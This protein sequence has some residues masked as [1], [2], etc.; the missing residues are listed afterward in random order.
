MKVEDAIIILAGNGSRMLP[1]SMYCP[2]EFL[3]LVNIPLIHHLVWEAVS[4]G[5]K[6]LHFVTSDEKLPFLNKMIEGEKNLLL[7]RPDLHPLH[8]KPILPEIEVK[9]HIQVKPKGVGDAISLGCKSIEGPFLVLLGDNALF[10]NKINFDQLGPHHPSDAC[11]ILIR[12][13]YSNNTPSIGVLK[14]PKSELYKYGVVELENNS[15]KNI[16]EKPPKSTAPSNLII[17]GRY[18]FPDGSYEILEKLRKNNDS[19]FLS[20]DFLNHLLEKN[21][22]SAVE[23]KNFELFDSGNP[24]SWFHDQQKLFSK[25]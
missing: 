23:F 4:S 10:N 18:L 14:K 22:L 21:S 19:E 3:P 7:L 2:K 11:S 16:I 6:R 20:I 1:A 8:H 5:I 15:I 17:C 25:I 13:Y 9:I 24:I 12:E